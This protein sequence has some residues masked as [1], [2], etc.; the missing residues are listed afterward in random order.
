[1]EQ[2]PPCAPE[3]RS[4]A[5]GRSDVLLHH[6]EKLFSLLKHVFGSF[7]SVEEAFTDAVIRWWRETDDMAEAE[8]AASLFR[9]AVEEAE[10]HRRQFGTSLQREGSEQEPTSPLLR[11]LR[12]LPMEYRLMIVLVDVLGYGRELAAQVLERDYNDVV[13]M[14]SRARRM[15]RRSLRQI[16]EENPEFLCFESIQADESIDGTESL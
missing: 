13:E 12:F 3:Q 11:S 4:S 8:S 9:I 5:L 2:F 6:E 16:P 7:C 1:M 15:V 10:R 14:L